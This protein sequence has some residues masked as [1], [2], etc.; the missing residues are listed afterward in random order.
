MRVNLRR[1]IAFVAAL[2]VP[3][4]AV[5]AL[6]A[7]PAL[8]A[9]PRYGRLVLGTHHTVSPLAILFTALGTAGGLILLVIT[10]RRRSRVQNATVSPIPVA[11]DHPAATDGGRRAA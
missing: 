11:V 9:L 2:I 3:A 4:V 5:L 7:S 8:A 1:R 10:E 6:S